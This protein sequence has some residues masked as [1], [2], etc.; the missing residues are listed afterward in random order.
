MIIKYKKVR[1]YQSG[2]IGISAS[3]FGD[4]S[5]YTTSLDNT[6]KKADKLTKKTTDSL[7]DAAGG[8]MDMTAAGGAAA[9][10]AG[11]IVAGFGNDMDSNYTAGEKWADVGG[12]ALKGAAAGASFGPI[13][14]AAGAVI[15]GG[16][17]AFKSMG[18]QKEA[19]ALALTEDRAAEAATNS[20]GRNGA[21]TRSA[22]RAAVSNLVFGNPIGGGLEGY[23]AIGRNGLKFARPKYTWKLEETGDFINKIE[24]DTHKI[25]IFKKGG[26]IK[27]TENMIPNGVLH[28]EKNSLGDKGMPVVK[29]SIKSKK[30]S[31]KYEI[32][33]DEMILTLE[34]TRT[35]EK[36]AK[37]GKF[38]ELGKFVQDQILNNTHSFTDKFNHLNSKKNETIYA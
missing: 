27:A 9:G 6:M 32:E 22:N 31:K 11:G 4:V 3:S 29:C 16:V 37:A 13:G 1:K 30:C 38:K 7:T 17:A 25:P 12:G 18:A 36:L 35:V 8:G 2:G 33:K 10:I 21:S 19:D 15:G 14:M 5:K 28:E 34:T 23:T 20:T 24:K 26:K